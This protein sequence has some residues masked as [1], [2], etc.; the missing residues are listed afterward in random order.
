MLALLRRKAQSTFIQVIIVAII[1]VF[2]F[3]GVGGQQ[4]AGVNAV[5]TVN[6]VPISYL[7]FQRAYA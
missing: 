5:A 6:D 7:D 4:G 3:W 1:L 2:V